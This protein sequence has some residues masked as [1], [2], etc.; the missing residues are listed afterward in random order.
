VNREEVSKELWA[1]VRRKPVFKDLHTLFE[2]FCSR[3]RHLLNALTAPGTH[4]QQ[5]VERVGDQTIKA[6]LH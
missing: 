3:L 4:G 5:T 6:N 1:V 2:V